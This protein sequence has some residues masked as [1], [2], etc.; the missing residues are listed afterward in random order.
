MLLHGHD[1]R[2]HTGTGAGDT[3]VTGDA[4]VSLTPRRPALPPAP[5][6]APTRTG[7]AWEPRRGACAAALPACPPE[8]PP[9]RTASAAAQ[10]PRRPRRSRW[11]R[12]P[13]PRPA[14]AS[15]SPRRPAAPRPRPR[16]AG[17]A[18]T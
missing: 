17:L 3:A 18:R 5:V 8:T 13:R 1:E 10:G 11:P 6:L 9:T 2:P 12:E 4:P 7:T 14:P 16:P 15:A